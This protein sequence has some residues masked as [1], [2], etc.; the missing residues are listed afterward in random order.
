VRG[1]VAS[2]DAGRGVGEIDGHDGATYPFHSTVIADGSRTI[3]DGSEV[4]FDVVPGHLG[5]WEAA[6]VRPANTGGES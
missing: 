1:T 4:E 3:A 5:L 6:A 2:F